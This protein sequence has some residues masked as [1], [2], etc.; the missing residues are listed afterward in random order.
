MTQEMTPLQEKY[1]RQGL[2]DCQH[3]IT[4]LQIP[5]AIKREIVIQCRAA[6]NQRDN[7]HCE[8]DHQKHHA[9]LESRTSLNVQV[10]EEENRN[11]AHALLVVNRPKEAL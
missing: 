10:V 1:Y 4:G 3:I 6:L 7:N 2:M 9:L 8:T 11:A 5:H